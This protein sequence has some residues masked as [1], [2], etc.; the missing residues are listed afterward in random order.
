[1]RHETVA[2]H[3]NFLLLLYFYKK[4][5]VLANYATRSRRESSVT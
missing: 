3:F 1:M 5:K 4:L 2:N